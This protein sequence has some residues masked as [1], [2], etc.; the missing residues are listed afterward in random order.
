MLDRECRKEGDGREELV[1]ERVL[2]VWERDDRG[3]GGEE[4]WGG[5]GTVY[6]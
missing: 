4:G 2:E 3:G 5:G 1:G 6:Q